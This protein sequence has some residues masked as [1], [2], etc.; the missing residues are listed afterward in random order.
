MASEAKTGL[1]FN[2]ATYEY[3]MNTIAKY[4]RQIYAS[5][6]CSVEGHRSA[7]T[8]FCTADNCD[9]R[10]LC[11]ECLVRDVKHTV[12]HQV[13]TITINQFIEQILVFNIDSFIINQHKLQ[14]VSD[15][16]E[17]FWKG[18]N[19]CYKVSSVV[20]SGEFHPEF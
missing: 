9:R 7:P 16:Y 8:S 19:I 6:K 3:D 2:K 14:E 12:E 4:M 13:H 15:F 1:R 17:T 10:L 11:P 18:L 5:M 20:T